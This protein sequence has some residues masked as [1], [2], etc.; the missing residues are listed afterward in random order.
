MAVWRRA[1]SCSPAGDNC[2]E[3]RRRADAV[4]IRDSKSVSST[5]ATSQVIT[6]GAAAWRSFVT[7]L[8]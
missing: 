1:S 4:D 6:V 2:V 8:G 5:S 7:A 3:V